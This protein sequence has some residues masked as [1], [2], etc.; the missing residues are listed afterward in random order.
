MRRSWVFVVLALGCA[1]KEE[2]S[3]L[4]V[5]DAA[6]VDSAVV[7]TAVDAPV[8]ANKAAAC[9]ST[10]GTALTAPY[11]R[12][13]GVVTAIVGP[14]D[15]DCA[16]PNDD[17]VVVQM[18]IDGAIYRMVVNVLSDRG[19]DLRIRIGELEHALPSPAWSEGWHTG[20]TLDYPSMLGAHTTAGFVPYEMLPAA[21]KVADT[22]PLGAKVS[23]YAITSGGAS[24]HKV[25][26]NDS[27]Q[28]GAIVIEPDSAKPRWLLFHFVTQTF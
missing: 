17:H 26:R 16:L 4:V 5:E 14:T 3:P 20:V 13:D 12:A 23:V 28:D 15:K 24:A 9:A 18:R 27:N 1:G 10:F 7:E 2:S 22:I 25:H 6:V 21:Q 11:G 19:S 8:D